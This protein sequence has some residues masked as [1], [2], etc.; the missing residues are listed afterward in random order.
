MKIFIYISVF[1]LAY[2]AGSYFVDIHN[3]GVIDCQN[4]TG[5]SAERCQTELMR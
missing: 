4:Q 3:Q 1:F 2:A 5:W